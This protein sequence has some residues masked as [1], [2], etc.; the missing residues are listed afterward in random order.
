MTTAVAPKRFADPGPAL[1]LADVPGLPGEV[2]AAIAARGLKTLADLRP[3][4]E[5]EAATDQQCEPVF[6]LLAKWDL[7]VLARYKAGGALVDLLGGRAHMLRT[8]A[9]WP[10]A[11]PAALVARPCPRCSRLLDRLG[12]CW[13]CCDWLCRCGSWS[14][15]PLISQCLP[16]QLAAE[17]AERVR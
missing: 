1:A 2:A 3:L 9:G 16:C 8:M 5:A 4:I 15:S 14:G 13:K 7:P 12:R 6:A 17:R 11:V 10:A